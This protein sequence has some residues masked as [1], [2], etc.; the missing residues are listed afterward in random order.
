MFN[1]SCLCHTSYASIFCRKIVNGVTIYFIVSSKID[2]SSLIH[3]SCLSRNFSITTEKAANPAQPTQA[4][5]G[6]PEKI[7]NTNLLH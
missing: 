6:P 5:F 4:A 1:L 7:T 3:E 2:V